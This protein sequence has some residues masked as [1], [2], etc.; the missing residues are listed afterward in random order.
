VEACDSII[1]EE[2]LLP[3][4]QFQVVAEIGSRLTGVHRLYGKARR[5]PPVQGGEDPHAQL[6]VERRLT[7]ATR[8]FRIQLQAKPGYRYRYR[9][10]NIASPWSTRTNKALA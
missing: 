10:N 8:R 4:R 2:R 7:W 1:G 9:A 6:A 3:P 5:D